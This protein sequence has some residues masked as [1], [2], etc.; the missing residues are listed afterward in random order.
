MRHSRFCL[1]IKEAQGFL[2]VSRSTL[3]QFGNAKLSY[4][5]DR[6]NIPILVVISECRMIE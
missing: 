1:S 2:G 3:Q 6:R 5:N 4:G